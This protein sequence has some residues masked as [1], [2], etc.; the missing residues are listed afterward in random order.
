MIDD[1]LDLSKIESGNVKLTIEPVKI[2]EVVQDC[3]A[4]SHPQANKHGVVISTEIDESEPLVAECDRVRLKQVLLNLLSNGI[5]Y[6]RTSGWL[7]V[8]VF[9]HDEREVCISVED[10]GYGIPE[11]KQRQLFQPFNRLGAEKTAI[12]G[13]GVGLVITKSLVE[14]MGGD[15]SVYSQK[16]VGSCFEIHLPRCMDDIENPVGPVLETLLDE[17]RSIQLDID[18]PKKI[19]FIEDNASNA[20]LMSKLFQHINNIQLDIAEE[21]LLGVYKARIQK[22]DVL[23]LDLSE[24]EAETVDVLKILNS[25]QDTS[26]IPK[27]A[28]VGSSNRLQE[29]RLEELGV[30]SLLTKPIN[31]EQLMAALQKVLQQPQTVGQN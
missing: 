27:L 29:K 17:N 28:F 19:L 21:P 13:S 4:L 22:P 1:V 24:N 31:V 30:V 8:K 16:D 3:V 7:A 23:L 5:K 25:D 2:P 12:E 15:I 18:Q 9:V 10:N 26:A 14:I 20:R 11:D 6:N